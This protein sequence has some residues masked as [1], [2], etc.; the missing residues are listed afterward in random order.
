[1]KNRHSLSYLPVV[2]IIMGIA[3]RTVGLGFIP[4]GVNQ[5]EAFAAY[6]AYCLAH[7]GM[8]SWGYVY[9]V[10]FISWGSG[11]NVLLSYLAIPWVK[12]LGLDVLSVRIP[13]LIASCL[14]LPAFY[15]VMRKLFGEK[16]GQVAL[17]LLCINPW[18]ITMSRW[19]LEANLAPAFLTFGLY[20][21]LKGEEHPLYLILSAVTY[22][23]CLYTYALMW[24]VV[25]LT[26]LFQFIYALYR[27]KIKRSDGR[28]WLLSAG[29]LFILALPLILFVLV[30]TDKV[31]EIRT[32]FFSVPHLKGQRMNEVSVYGIGEKLHNSLYI[33]FHQADSEIQ[34]GTRQ[35][36]LY[37]YISMVFIPV[38]I[39]I[40]GMG[41]RKKADSGVLFLTWAAAVPLLALT[42]VMVQRINAL[43]IPM[44]ALGAVGLVTVCEWMYKLIRRQ[45]LPV[46]MGVYIVLFVC[47]T[48]YYFTEYRDQVA[49][50]FQ[51]GL[52]DAV[53]RVNELVQDGTESRTEEN[54]D[55]Y[56]QKQMISVCGL[57]FSRI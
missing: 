29:I 26:L 43:H 35:Y 11:M 20:F 15:G 32:S 33:L 45:A 49:V 47:F 14:T 37:Y 41:I 53:Q 5:D 16:T 9:P 46:M 30:N 3:V 48:G 28:I 2:L 7:D 56:E 19:G 57:F 13:M 1:M 6:E 22:G 36:G 8:V 17:F 27:R 50:N 54:V 40:C 44:I 4:E 52:G 39:V 25:P 51:A 55:Q 34:N 38:G 10:Y 18:H 42:T 24:L 12:F 21:F 31:Q 23:I